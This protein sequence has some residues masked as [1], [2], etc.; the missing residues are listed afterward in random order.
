MPR[1]HSIIGLKLKFKELYDELYWQFI[2]ELRT[3]NLY[4]FDEW[5]GNTLYL[6]FSERTYDYMIQFIKKVAKKYNIIDVRDGILYMY[7]FRMPG[8]RII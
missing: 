7:G 5:V 2:E 3:E 6:V 8:M 1:L 4:F